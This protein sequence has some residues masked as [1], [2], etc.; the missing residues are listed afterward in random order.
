MND[1]KAKRAR[2]KSLYSSSLWEQ[3]TALLARQ[4]AITWGDKFELFARYFSI[5]IQALLYGSVF[6]NLPNSAVGG[7]ARAGALFGSLVDTAMVLY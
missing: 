3:F 2:K 7:Y 5:V 4:A 1:A 6:Y